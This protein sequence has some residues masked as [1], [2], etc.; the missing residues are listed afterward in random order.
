MGGLQYKGRGNGD[1]LSS[2]D[3]ED[4]LNLVDGRE[5]LIDEIAASS[6]EV[7]DYIAN[8]I[9]ALLDDNNFAYAISSLARGDAGREDLLYERLTQLS[10]DT[11]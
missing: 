7:R 2:R 8:E 11:Q 10:R 9:Q 4:I 3:I 5:E 1:A 6:T